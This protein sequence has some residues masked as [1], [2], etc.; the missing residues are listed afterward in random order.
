VSFVG[1]PNFLELAMI[2]ERP[3]QLDGKDVMTE[4][5]APLSVPQKRAFPLSKMIQSN[6]SVIC[7]STFLEIRISNVVHAA[8]LYDIFS[9]A[10]PDAALEICSIDLAYE[11]ICPPAK[12]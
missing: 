6:I 2:D 9:I 8:S 10:S 11:F 4:L 3:V 12:F 1:I 7:C 5:V